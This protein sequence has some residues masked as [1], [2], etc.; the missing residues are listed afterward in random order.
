MSAAHMQG[1]STQNR[2]RTPA[3]VPAGGQFATER[4]GESSFNTLHHQ[5][6][7][8]QVDRNGLLAGDSLEYGHDTMGPYAHYRIDRDGDWTYR[9]TGVVVEP[10]IDAIPEEAAAGLDEEGCLAYLHEREHVIDDFLQERYGDRGEVQLHLSDD[11]EVPSRV[12]FSTSLDDLDE[13][14]EEAG[15]LS[16]W[17]GTRGHTFYDEMDPGTTGAENAQRLLR[18]RL[19]AHDASL[20]L[21]HPQP[22]VPT[23]GELG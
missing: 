5:P 21:E 1:M 13:I 18:E 9:A 12:E 6:V 15:S 17:E 16:V 3:G 7:G 23:R 14:T 8:D 11:P 19:A 22:R 20:A 4:R 10:F 2:N